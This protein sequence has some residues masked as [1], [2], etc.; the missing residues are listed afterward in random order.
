MDTPVTELLHK[1]SIQQDL[2]ARQTRDLAQNENEER[3]ARSTEVRTNNT[4]PTETF[5]IT[6]PPGNES[7]VDED[8]GLELAEVKKE[9]EEAKERIQQQELQI[10]Q[11]RLAQYTMEEAIG[12]PFPSASQLAANIS[13]HNMLGHGMGPASMYGDGS[14]ASTATFERGSF[15]MPQMQ[16]RPS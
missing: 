14:R 11:S 5:P 12:S 2:L 4:S 3:T 10:T 13:G 1:L 8:A 6:T 15:N 16:A 7:V 9:L